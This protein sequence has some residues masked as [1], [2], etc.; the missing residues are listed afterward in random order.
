MTSEC[1]T[2]DFG[3]IIPL[4]VLAVFLVLLLTVVRASIF[5]QVEEAKHV[6][7]EIVFLLLLAV[8]GE[9]AVIHLRLPSVMVL[10]ILGILISSSF[11]AMSWDFLKSLDL[12]VTL[13]SSLPP[14]VRSEQIL[15]VFA[16]LG[17][18]ILLFKVG[19]H[20][21]IEGIFRMD[22]LVVAASGVLLPF[23]VGYLYAT[24]TGGNFAYSM[25]LGAALTATSVGVTVALL[26]EAGVMEAR[27]AQ[28]IIGAAVI[29]DVLGLLIL[30]FVIN[31]AS[32]DGSLAPLAFTLVSVFVFLFGSIMAGDYFIRYLDRRGMSPRRFLLVLAFMLLYAYVAEF[33]K[34]SAIVGAFIAGV[35]INRSRHIAEIEQSTYGLELLFLPIFFISLGML[36][37]VNALSAYALPILVITFL[38]IVTKVLSCGIASLWAGLSRRESLLVGVGMSPRG[39]VALIVASIGLTSSVLKVAEYSVIATMALLT[40]FLTPP[41]LSHLLGSAPH[42]KV[43]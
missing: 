17:A 40:T 3:K 31:M 25:F 26:R 27:F 42:S 6:Y 30:S 5:G 13:P 32:G 41:L 39:E 10:M 34:L 14:I 12:P 1:M 8:V 2:P 11:L 38:A 16:Q 7:F 33:I 28:I 23:L 9:L 22:N 20:N 35:V 18:I 37:D 24:S 4:A 43:S 36:V 29:D 19:L 21:R 15:Q